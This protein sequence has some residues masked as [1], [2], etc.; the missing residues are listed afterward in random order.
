MDNDQNC[1]S[2]I[3]LMLTQFVRSGKYL[4]ERIKDE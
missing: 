3:C 4:L 1:D 2:Y